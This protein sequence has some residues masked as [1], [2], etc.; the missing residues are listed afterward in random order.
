MTSQLAF[1]V[2]LFAMCAAAIASALSFST[3]GRTFPWIISV[4]LI[5]LILIEAT[6]HLRGLHFARVGHADPWVS[7]RTFRTHA[8]PVLWIGFAYG[9]I[10]LLGFLVGLVAFLGIYLFAS[11]YNWRTAIPVPLAFGAVAYF[12]FQRALQVQLYSGFLFES[13]GF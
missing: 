7:A 12:G 4:A 3:G 9:C 5:C 2:F 8:V 11:G 6:R 10:Y 13:I 1:L